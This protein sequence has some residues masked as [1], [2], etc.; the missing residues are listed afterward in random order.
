VMYGAAAGISFWLE[1]AGW[2]QF[3][4]IRVEYNTIVDNTKANWGGILLMSSSPADFGTGNVIRNN[5]IMNNGNWAIRDGWTNDAGIA[6]RFAIDH[7]LFRAGENISAA[8]AGAITT[9]TSP[10]VN[11]AGRD[12]HLTPTSPARNIGQPISD[13]TVNIEG[14]QRAASLTD[15]GAY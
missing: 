14:A 13:V 4:N 12:F 3:E 15:A 10:F 9:S 1:T 8:G 5:I 7:N 6:R 2:E 11:Q